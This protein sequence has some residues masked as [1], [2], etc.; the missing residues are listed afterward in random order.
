MRGK[1]LPTATNEFEVAEQ[2][3]EEGRFVGDQQIQEN[4]MF[5]VN[6]FQ[7]HQKCGMGV[8]PCMELWLLP[9]N[10]KKFIN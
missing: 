1:F 4:V 7:K 9:T 2:V 3:E 8:H 5:Q 10:R 6:S